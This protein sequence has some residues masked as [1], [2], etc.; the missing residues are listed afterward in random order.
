MERKSKGTM[1]YKMKGHTLPGIK[2]KKGSML[3]KEP[4]QEELMARADAQFGTD[5]KL[6]E[7]KQIPDADFNLGKRF[8]QSMRS[9]QSDTWGNLTDSQ[10]KSY[11]RKAAAANR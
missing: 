2:Q 4:T 11:I 7:A 8:Y 10:K 5:N 1:A 3:R 9:P 6:L